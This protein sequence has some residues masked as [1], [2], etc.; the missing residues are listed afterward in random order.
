[1][2][3]IRGTEELGLAFRACFCNNSG[4]TKNGE[5][6]DCEVLIYIFLFSAAEFIMDETLVRPPLVKAFRAFQIVLTLEEKLW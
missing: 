1:M 5:I 4:L 3:K 6:Y 2:I